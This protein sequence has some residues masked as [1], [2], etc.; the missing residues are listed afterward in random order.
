[1]YPEAPVKKGGVLCRFDDLADPGSKGFEPVG[2]DGFF[3]VRKGEQVYGYVN[4]CPHYRSP[5]EWKVDTFLDYDETNIL[6][7]LHG[8]LFRIEDGY[9]FFG[10]CGGESLKRLAIRVEDGNVIL[11]E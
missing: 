11:D 9:C 6:C 10:P 3:V 2:R 8:A 1:M 7:S 4:V 5:L